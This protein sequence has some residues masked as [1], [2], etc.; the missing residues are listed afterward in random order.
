MQ[1]GSRGQSANTAA[2]AAHNGWTHHPASSVSVSTHLHTTPLLSGVRWC[3]C[4]CCQPCRRPRL[5]CVWTGMSPALQHCWG[6]C[7]AAACYCCHHHQPVRADK[8]QTSRKKGVKVRPCSQRLIAERGSCTHL[9]KPMCS[10]SFKRDVIPGSPS[11]FT[12]PNKTN[13]RDASN[14]GTQAS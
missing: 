5:L 7:C 14:H 3:A 4:T 8:A 12:E 13:G 1:C 2:Q 9:T 6:S 10:V 11:G